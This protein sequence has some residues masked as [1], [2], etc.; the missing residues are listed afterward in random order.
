MAKR[1]IKTALGTYTNA[2]GDAG[3]FGYRGDEV[4]VHADDLDRFDSLN[5][6]PGEDDD[7]VPEPAQHDAV[8]SPAAGAETSGTESGLNTAVEL[9]DEG[10]PVDDSTAEDD[11]S[12]EEAP[13]KRAAARK[14]TTTRRKR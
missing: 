5:H 11:A 3:C 13:R 7:V 10:D 14:S 4:D 9:D 12:D 8:V 2:K 6:Q 1:T